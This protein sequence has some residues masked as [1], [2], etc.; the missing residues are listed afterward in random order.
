M[1]VLVFS[2]MLGT[3]QA[4]SIVYSTTN[5]S[6]FNSK[7]SY[8]NIVWEAQID[9]RGNY[10]NL[11]RKSD[12]ANQVVGF[13]LNMAYET[14]VSLS[15][16][17]GTLSLAALIDSAWGTG[18][19][20]S[21]NVSINSL[22]PI[23][24]LYMSIESY[25]PPVGNATV[26]AFSIDSTSVDPTLGDVPTSTVPG[27]IFMGEEI[28][29]GST[30]DNFTSGFTLATTSPSGSMITLYGIQT[31]PEPGTYALF[32]GGLVAFQFIRRFR[33]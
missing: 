5:Q 32:G 18:H 14:K 23:S 2:M 27:N 22:L 29:L 21:A 12:N 26:S 17:S 24:G 33:K 20:G 11:I 13:G 1:F 15:L 9:T 31:V 30:R 7:I 3:S 25:V 8:D 16:N 28:N 6:G 10:I 4:Q 19:T